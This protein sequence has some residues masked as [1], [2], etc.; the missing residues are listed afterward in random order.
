[1]SYVCL[2]H[3]AAG[4]KFVIRKVRDGRVKIYGRW[5]YSETPGPQLEG[6]RFAFGLYWERQPQGWGLLNYCVLWGTEACYWA[7]D[8]D[9]AYDWECKAQ[10]SILQDQEGYLCWEY[11]GVKREE[12]SQATP[13]EAI[14]SHC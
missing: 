14:A 5:F 9:A 7:L 13:S 10:K 11:W 6:L 1:M 2:I 8:D 4:K 12:D 3:R